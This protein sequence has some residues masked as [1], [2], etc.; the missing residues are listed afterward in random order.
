M[1]SIV[2]SRGEKSPVD[3]VRLIL[4]S[5]ADV[6][7]GAAPTGM[8]DSLCAAAIA[9]VEQ[10]GRKHSFQS[11]RG[12]SILRGLTPLGHAAWIGDPEMTQLLLNFRA[13]PSLP[14]SIGLFP[15]DLAEENGHYHLLPM[16]LVSM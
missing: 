11:K 10:V 16:L 12:F 3:T 5:K 13:D 4:D 7:L 15:E 8:F 6:N 2:H 9:E 14:C 1:M